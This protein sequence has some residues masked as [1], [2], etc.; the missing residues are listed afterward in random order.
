MKKLFSIL[1]VAIAA[2]TFAFASRTF[3]G[4]E[5][6]Y[7][8]A[9]GNNATWWTNGNAVQRAVLDNTT[10]VIGVVESGAIY[11]FTLPAGEYSTIRFER[12]ES[13]EAAAWNATGDIS[14][15]ATENYVTVF[16]QDS[17]EATWDTYTYTLPTILLRGSFNIWGESD[18]FTNNGETATFTKTLSSGTHEFKITVGGVWTSNN[19]TI[20]RENSGTEYE[21]TNNVNDNAQLNADMDGE[22]TFTYTYATNKLSVTFPTE[23]VVI[24]HTYT[25]A[26]VPSVFDSEWDPSDGDN[27][28]TN[29]EGTTYTWSKEGITLAAGTISFKVCEDRS[30]DVAYPA[31]NYNLAIE[32]DGIYSISITFDSNS[33]AINA[34]ANKTGDAVVIPT[35]ILNG[36]FSG[37]WADAGELEGDDASV[38][39]TIS[40]LAAG[41]YEFGIKSNGT[42]TSN[43]VAFTRENT[44]AEVVSGTG[45]LTLKAD[46]T[47][48]YTFTWTFETHT[49][50]ITYPAVANQTLYFVNGYDWD[51]Q[52]AY[53][54]KESMNYKTWPGEAMTATESSVF[55]KTIYSYEFPNCYNTIIFNNKHGEDYADGEQTA[56]LEWDA[57]KPYFFNGE[58][59]ASVAEIQSIF[60]IT[61]SASLVGEEK[62]WHADA[63]KVTEDSYTFED[64]AANYYELKV[65]YGGEWLGFDALASVPAGVRTNTDGNIAFYLAEAGDVTIAFDKEAKE[66]TISGSF[67]HL[68]LDEASDNN[69]AISALNGIYVPISLT[70]SFEDQKLYTLCLPFD[71]NAADVAAILHADKLYKLQSA[72]VGSELLIY[73]DIVDA[74]EAGVPY[75]YK[76]AE[77]VANPNFLGTVDAEAS[78]IIERDGVSMVGFYEPTTTT[79][80]YFL[81]ADTYLHQSKATANAFRAYFTIPGGT[82][83]MPARI[84]MRGN[85]T[86]AIDKIENGNAQCTK[87]IQNGQLVIIRD[88]KTFNALGA[89]LR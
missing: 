70:R 53:V 28:M 54:F 75:L 80:G 19:T 64:L 67:A 11:A 40:N 17:P 42:W 89:E 45:N 74:I 41:K 58:W 38:S 63:I 60:Y 66:I 56:D 52:Q 85:S 83:N 7:F 5:K 71:V 86:T 34:E 68:D 33:K 29:T 88:G 55:G 37:V 79:T 82:N 73:F 47:G 21:F 22:Y 8:N 72:S 46:V 50:A 51:L 16:A 30:W 25:V 62:A 2:T 77:N 20:Q 49:L 15:P 44:S 4:S 43:G 9:H 65:V 61:G 6:I 31:Q 32:A 23:P 27:D 36:T 87:R 81:G 84:V 12:A 69:A 10:S 59:Y 76:P 26:G 78:T 48:D 39:L 3:D 35:I 57:T 1:F 18:V 14:I 24:T 13:A